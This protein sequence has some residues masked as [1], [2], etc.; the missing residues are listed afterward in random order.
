MSEQQGK[1]TRM[2]PCSL[3]SHHHMCWC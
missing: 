3:A 2:G 1:A